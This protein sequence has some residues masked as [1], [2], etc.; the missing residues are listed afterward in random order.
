MKNLMKI[1]VVFAALAAFSCVTDATED[2]GVNVGGTTGQTELTLSLEQSRTQLGEKAGDLYPVFWS[3]GDKISVNGIESNAAAISSNRSVATFSVS[4]V[5]NTPYCIAYPAAPAGQ[6]LFAEKQAHS[7][8]STFA[9]GV[10]TMYGYSE[11]GFGIA[12]K[13]LTGILK[14]GVVGEAKLAMVQVSTIDRAPIAGAFA[15]DYTTGEVTPTADSKSLIEYSLGEGLQLSEETNFLHLAVPA[16]VYNELY[17]TLYDTDGGV[18]YATVKASDENPL[19][20]GKLRE[21]SNHIYYV[22]T[23]S[24]FVIKDKASLL[25][26]AAQAATLESDALF[27]A[28]IDMTGEAWTPIQGYSKTVNGNGYAI[29]GLTAPLF[30]TT[31]AS[32]KGLHLKDVVLASNEQS[33][34]AGLA[35]K[36]LA[37]DSK[38]PVIEHCSVSGTLTVDNKSYSPTSTDSIDALLY[39]G[40]IAYAQGVKIDNCVSN[41]DINVVQG[42]N[43]A[44]TVAS[45][46]HI[47]GIAARIDA[48]INTTNSESVYTYVT[49]CT[50]NG[51]IYMDDV[52][53]PEV[54]GMYTPRFAGIVA[55][56]DDENVSPAK[57]ANCTN[58]GPITIKDITHNTSKTVMVAGIV[59]YNSKT[60]MSNCV[61]N[62]SAK[63]TITGSAKNLYASNIGAYT[64]NSC[65]SNIINYADIEVTAQVIDNLMVAGILASPSNSDTTGALHFTAD[66]L[67]NYGNVV[68]NG[69]STTMRVGGVIG[70]GS[71][72]DIYNSTN[73]GN[74]TLTPKAGDKKITISFGG[75][76]AEATGDGDA[77]ILENCVNYGN[78][79]LDLDG[80]NT[81][82]TARAAAL[83]GYNHQLISKCINH[84]DLIVKGACTFTT[85][86][87][88]DDTTTDSNYNFGAISG[89]KAADKGQISETVNNGNVIFEAVVTSAESVA[90]CIQIGGLAGRTHQAIYDTNTQNGK[91]LVRGD[92]SNSA[93]I[94][95]VGGTVGVSHGSTKSGLPNSGDIHITGSYGKVYV[96]GNV[97]LN[98]LGSLSIITKATN[99]GN[100]HLGINEKDEV[101][102]TTFSQCPFVGGNIG[103]SDKYFTYLTNSGNIRI[104][105]NIT[106]TSSNTYIAGCVGLANTADLQNSCNNLSNSGN[107]TFEGGDFGAT[108]LSMGGCVGY[109]YGNADTNHTYYN[110]GNITYKSNVKS[111]GYIRLGG[112]AP[113][114]QCTVKDM[115][116]DG[117]ISV[118]SDTSTSLYIGGIVS[119]PNGYNRTTLVNNGNILVDANIGYDCFIGGLCYELKAGNKKVWA[120][121][122]NNGNIE[123]S[124][125][126]LISNNLAIGGLIGKASTSGE[127]KIFQNC[128]NNGNITDYS[129]TKG[130]HI[131]GG[132]IGYLSNGV[133]IIIRDSFINNGTITYG[134]KTDG[135]DNIYVAGVIGYGYTF[136]YD[137]TTWTGNVINNG[138]LICSGTSIG[139][140]YHVGGIIASTGGSLG[141]AVNLYNFGDIIVTGGGG[142]KNG[143]EGIEQVGGI[144][145]KNAGFPIYNGNVYCT[146]DAKEANY[147]GFICGTARSATVTATNCNLGGELLGEYNIEDETYKT[148]TLTAENY[149]DYIFGGTTDWSGVEAYDGCNVLTEKPTIPTVE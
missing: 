46:L 52:T 88:L 111:A 17:V 13:H 133:G 98:S 140:G 35:C 7:G 4:G 100:I 25:D 63:I 45:I 108:A 15:I 120:N 38:S 48:Y 96:G 65:W 9:S 40:V 55:L 135:A 119:N 51:A 147:V 37:T 99:S 24:L 84:G 122:V 69:C 146:I 12:M 21:F 39:G 41:V 34:V 2:L 127:N 86:N 68:V 95:C 125:N 112:I 72:G 93:A 131:L 109:M 116:N 54:T 139:G 117:D 141:E 118:L 138:N 10:S 42:M 114:L 101:V 137:T 64:F 28:D 97:G 123:I 33:A 115:T 128:V 80:C 14:I 53:Q 58:N 31:S 56:S 94:L 59:A 76:E 47:A 87:V 105:A 70:R 75:F 6:V 32:I 3:E 113:Y 73:Y 132:L 106:A 44:C 130:S 85:N 11:E 67:V 83:S 102:P 142:V 129:K 103:C 90:P 78:A 74:V 1:F 77:G 50:N 148:T 144:V 89:Y 62:K 107:I 92:T 81:V 124:K 20:A 36:V 91:L 43:S 126:S 145:G 49:N 149:F 121:C 66:G 110:S 134:G 5:L 136:S 26:F 19:K 61:N 29:K 30:G 23:A 60:E 104:N 8:N 27:V 82:A 16:G 22:P 18:M 143:V 57:M 79:I 71:Q